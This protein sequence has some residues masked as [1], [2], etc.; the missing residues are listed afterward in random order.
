MQ[1]RGKLLVIAK[2]GRDMGASRLMETMGCKWF[3]W[4]LIYMTTNLRT[5]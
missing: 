5:I 2:E 1:Q 4:G 3:L